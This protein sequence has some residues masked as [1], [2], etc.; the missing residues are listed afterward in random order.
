MRKAKNPKEVLEHLKSDLDKRLLTGEE[1]EK[2]KHRE[3]D[4][5]HGIHHFDEYGNHDDY[6]EDEFKP[7]HHFKFSK[8]NLTF[9]ISLTAVF[10]ALSV[11]VSLLDILLETLALPVGDQVF[12]QTRFLDIVLVVT[13]IATLGPLFSSLLGAIQP[14]MHNL[15]HG[16]EHGWIQPMLDMFQNILIVWVVWLIFYII[17]QNSPIHR[18]ENK[19]VYETKRWV[20]MPIIV[21]VVA[22]I[23]TISFILALYIQS[24]VSPNSPL[25]PGHD[26]DHDHDHH[27]ML[28][29][30]AGVNLK[31]VFAIFGWNILRYGIA[32]VLFVLIEGRM[33]II[34]HRYK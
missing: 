20:P 8:K 5:Y 10:L 27:G 22:I 23:A 34:N 21:L 26:H 18:D 31:V 24:K 3:K 4:H 28:E 17:F 6:M 33:R 1:L 13:S 9:K 16:M 29:T 7:S 30:I 19:K 11:V 25:L 14:I 15:I 32:F 12:I 2:L